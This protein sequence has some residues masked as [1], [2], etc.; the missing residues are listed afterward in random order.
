M[1]HLKA[2]CSAPRRRERTAEYQRINRKKLFQLI[3]A[4]LFR[5]TRKILETTVPRRISTFFL[6]YLSDLDRWER[7]RAAAGVELGTFRN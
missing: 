2:G 3:A 6:A 7:E 1:L 5:K 4:T